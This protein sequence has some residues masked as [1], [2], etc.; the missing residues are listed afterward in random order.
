MANHL[1]PKWKEQIAAGFTTGAV[2]A[3]LF[4]GTAWADTMTTVADLVAA[5][6]TIVATSAALTG[7]SVTNGVLKAADASFGAVAAGAQ[8][9]GAALIQA[10]TD[11]SG[12]DL[13]TNQ[14]RVIMAIDTLTGDPGLPF[15]PDGRQYSITFDA[16]NGIAVI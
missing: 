10:N 14:Q 7:K 16:A 3:I 5:G 9:T 1:A 4:R 8:I 2:K 13:A 15:V 12:V 11:G 6:A